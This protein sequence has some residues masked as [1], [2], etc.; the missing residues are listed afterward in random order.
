MIDLVSVVVNLKDMMSFIHLFEY[1]KG[2]GTSLSHEIFEI[3]FK[4]GDRD[5]YRGFFHPQ[6]ITNPFKKRYKIPSLGYLMSAMSLEVHLAFTT[7]DLMRH[8][9]YPIQ[10]HAKLSV[11][12]AKFI[13]DF[14]KF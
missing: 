9:S 5:I 14:Y 10:K 13:Y 12:G 11:E 7:F 3:L 1:A 8:F 6:D 4:L 2:L